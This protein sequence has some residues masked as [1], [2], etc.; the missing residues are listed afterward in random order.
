MS[1]VRPSRTAVHLYPSAAVN[2]ATFRGVDFGYVAG[3][4]P[5]VNF[6][7]VFDVEAHFD[8]IAL[9]FINGSL[10]APL[11]ISK[12]TV[13]VGPSAADLTMNGAPYTAVTFA[14]APGVTVPVATSVAGLGTF[15]SYV[16]S[17]FVPLSSLARTDVIGGRPLVYTRT[18]LSPTVSTDPIAALQRAGADWATFPNA[19]G[20]Y[21]AGSYRATAN[22]VTTGV[23]GGTAPSS[24]GLSGP[25]VGAVYRARNGRVLTVFA[26]GDSEVLGTGTTS[27]TQWVQKAGWTASGGVTTVPASETPV[28][29]CYWGFAGQTPAT[30]KKAFDL[31]LAQV[32]AL[33]FNAC[34]WE[35][36]S[37][38]GAGTPPVSR[39]Y[40][41]EVLAKCENAS[42]YPIV[43]NGMP[44]ST[45][46]SQANDALRIA[47]NLEL[48]K[49]DCA[50]LDF[51]AVVTDNGTGA[52]A[53]I[54]SFKAG[55]SGDNLHPNNTGD[56]AVAAV[57]AAKL[58]QIAASYYGAK[59]T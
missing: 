30:Y 50:V 32:G 2:S 8:Q 12:A 21:F 41:A 3:T 38:N 6:Q 34:L 28:E 4:V 7:Q 29:T 17:D 36:F 25:C 45:I 15:P 40:T 5:F 18:Q 52:R 48:L 27:G 43:M 35:A 58:A 1:Q 33:P 14:G 20:R 24:T 13:N 16:V 19:Y 49:K 47:Y 39:Q 42:I 31:M 46:G 59:T 22:D 23:W 51:D 53:P 56:T 57:A 37:P 26:F 11:P 55:T 44:A 54:A 9:I 10:T